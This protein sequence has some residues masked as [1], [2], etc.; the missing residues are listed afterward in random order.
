MT[1]RLLLSAAPIPFLTAVAE[2]QG[3]GDAAGRGE[4]PVTAFG[5]AGDGKTLNTSSIQAAIDACHAAGGGRVILPRG[6]FVT[7]TIRLKSH[8]TLRVEAGAR[9]AGST[10]SDD[11]PKEGGECDWHPRFPW[12]R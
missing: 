2:A 1:R 5:A 10:R 3:P 9:L 12:G 11:Y 6:V 4:F 7:G 8:V